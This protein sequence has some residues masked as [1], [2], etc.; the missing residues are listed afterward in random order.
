MEEKVVVKIRKFILGATVLIA[1]MF[2]SCRNTN[3]EKKAF[4]NCDNEK[5][6]KEALEEENKVYQ[7][8][9]AFFKDEFIG[10]FPLNLSDG[11]MGMNYS[12]SNSID[13]VRLTLI[14]KMEKKKLSAIEADLKSNS[15]AK[16][17]AKEECLLIV[18]RFATKNNYINIQINT[19]DK[20]L[21]DRTCYKGKYPIPNFFRNELTTN[22]TECHLP[23]DFI[24]YVINA[25]KGAYIDGKLLTNGEYMPKEWR[26]G[27]SYGI[28]LSIQ[29]E[30]VIYWTIIW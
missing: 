25:K 7:D 19:D 10:H 5:L 27:V 14:E 11:Y 1:L 30:V 18:N 21:I 3:H 20:K 23:L 17:L 29:N 15:I 12:H 13:V 2:Y 6:K 4:S 16:Y 28:A 26:N 22:E 9:K 8:A 24:I